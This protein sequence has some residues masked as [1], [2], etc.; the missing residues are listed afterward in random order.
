MKQK[1]S[2]STA[3]V[4]TVAI[5]IIVLIIT[6][7]FKLEELPIQTVGVLF[8]GVITALITYFLLL[9]QLKPKKTKNET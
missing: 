5:F 9:G 2:V 3:L 7:L 6:K 8:G 1:I 4:V